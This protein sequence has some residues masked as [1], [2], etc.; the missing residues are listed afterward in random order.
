M[1]ARMITAVMLLVDNH[2]GVDQ[3]L[4]LS[5]LIS[6]TRYTTNHVRRIVTQ[7]DR[8]AETGSPSFEMF[9]DVFQPDSSVDES[10]HSTINN[11][12]WERYESPLHNCDFRRCYPYSS[13]CHL[14]DC[15]ARPYV[16]RSL[17]LLHN[18]M[19][20]VRRRWHRCAQRFTSRVF[21]R[22]Y[23]FHKSKAVATTLP[24]FQQSV[25]ICEP[26]GVSLRSD[27]TIMYQGYAQRHI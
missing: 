7:T 11:L 5:P 23:L 21:D 15:Q 26:D 14:R 6:F 10:P 20:A 12:P 13:N 18:G 16:S 4:Y 2:H 9:C 24:I 27:R 1:N 8:P 22:S 3:L 17:R 25:E 19:T